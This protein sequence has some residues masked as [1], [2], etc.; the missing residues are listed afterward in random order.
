LPRRA[1]FRFGPVLGCCRPLGNKF[2]SGRRELGRLMDIHCPA[3]SSNG[4]GNAQIWSLL[5]GRGA[6]TRD[7]RRPLTSNIAVNTTLETPDSMIRCVGQLRRRRVRTGTH[8]HPRNPVRR[9]P[10]ILLRTIVA[11]GMAR[12]IHRP[13]A[14]ALPPIATLRTAPPC[15]QQFA[16]A[17]RLHSLRE[18]YVGDPGSSSGLAQ[19]ALP[20]VTGAK[21]NRRRIGHRVRL[22]N[23]FAMRGTFS[24]LRY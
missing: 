19:P 10:L 21:V 6:R 16:P 24:A 7:V 15:R 11:V 22:A 20:Y 2:S 12:I 3:I 9:P 8:D 4:R 14:V 18:L 13:F 23:K 1:L 5:R 17:A